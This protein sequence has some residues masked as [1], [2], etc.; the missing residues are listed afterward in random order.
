MNDHVRARPVPAAKAAT[1]PLHLADPGPLAT[2]EG[3]LA[4]ARRTVT[5]PGLQ[6]SA[7]L[8][9]KVRLTDPRLA[10][11][12]TLLPLETDDFARGV[13]LARTMLVKNLYDSPAAARTSPSTDRD[14]PA[15]R[16]S[17][18]GSDSP[19]RAWSTT[20]SPRTQTGT[21]WC[22]STCRTTAATPCTGPCRSRSTSA[23]STPARP[24]R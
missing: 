17:P 7:P 4:R 23:W 16:Y 11:H 2:K 10:Y 1:H 5:P 8:G 15:S 20:T 19:S 22:T 6:D 9:T 18:P 13:H 12:G 21:R 24:R 3:F 14:L